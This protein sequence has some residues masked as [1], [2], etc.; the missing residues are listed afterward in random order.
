MNDTSGYLDGYS[1]EYLQGLKEQFYALYLNASGEG[2]N[3]RDLWHDINERIRNMSDEAVITSECGQTAKVLIPEISQDIVSIEHKGKTFNVADDSDA[4]RTIKNLLY[5][6]D[7]HK[8]N[9]FIP[10]TW[11]CRVVEKQGGTL[12]YVPS[13]LPSRMGFG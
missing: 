1:L 8:C 3:L 10:G 7:V 5:Q 12:I 4:W 9:E 6:S 2:P 11:N 13:I